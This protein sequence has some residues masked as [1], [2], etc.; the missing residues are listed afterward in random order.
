MKMVEVKRLLV[1]P[2]QSYEQF[3]EVMMNMKDSS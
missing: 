2:N 1:I 3:T